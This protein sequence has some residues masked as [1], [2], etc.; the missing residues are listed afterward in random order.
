MKIYRVVYTETGEVRSLWLGYRSASGSAAQARSEASVQV[1]SVPDDLFKP[2]DKAA[3]SRRARLE[4][5]WHGLDIVDAEEAIAVL[6]K[7]LQR[8]QTVYRRVNPSP[9]LPDA[10]KEEALRLLDR[11]VDVQ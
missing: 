4:N 5:L 3:E 2:V 1:A 10:A 11:M 7:H 8:R 9:V 6:T